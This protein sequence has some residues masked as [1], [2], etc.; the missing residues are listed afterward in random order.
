M[1]HLLATPRHCRCECRSRLCGSR[2]SVAKVLIKRPKHARRL[3]VS[4]DSADK[5]TNPTKESYLC[6]ATLI[7]WLITSPAT[8]YHENG[9]YNMSGCKLKK[10]T[11]RP[12]NTT[13]NIHCSHLRIYKK[14]H[15]QIFCICECTIWYGIIQDIFYLDIRTFSNSLVTVL[16]FFIFY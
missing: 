9:G 5:R 8:L 14:K 10:K 2:Q 15:L 3:L 1:R 13:W 12:E 11:Y 7:Y 16:V 4:R 6:E